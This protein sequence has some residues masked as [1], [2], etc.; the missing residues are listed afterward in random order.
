MSLTPE[1][2]GMVGGSDLPGI[3]GRSPWATPLSV[4]VRIVAALEGR[5]REQAPNAAMRRGNHLE[6]AVLAMYAEETGAVVT[7]KV[8]LRDPLRSYVRASLD[9][10]ADREGRI[11]VD[12]KTA[13]RDG[14]RKYGEP[15]T[16]QVP[17]EVIHQQTLYIGI[18]LRVGRVDVHAADIA[19]F[20][21]GEL[22][23]FRIPFDQDLFGLLEEAVD[24]FWMDH[25][26][27]RRPPPPSEPFQDLA[28]VGHLY[29]KHAGDAKHW[30]SLSAEGRVAVSEWL[31]AKEEEEKAAELRASWE[32]RAKLAMGSA[33]QL[34][35]LPE[36]LPTHR[37]DWKQNKAG[38]VTDWKG[39]AGA[40][41]VEYANRVRPS[42]YK[43]IVAE[44]TTTKEGARPFVARRR[45]D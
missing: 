3:L 22:A 42:R 25:V 33:P 27:P 36:H 8:N 15:G 38:T 24:R 18:G 7:P 19:A 45:G 41:A 30:D 10:V 4:Y 1:E 44:F 12:A 40:L 23:L 6:A 35:G 29:R 11:V 28:A 26:E 31:R 13:T 21:D 14:A 37:V 17:E 9:G 34:V 39:V 5:Y 20:L 43:E 32:V 16:D 2:A